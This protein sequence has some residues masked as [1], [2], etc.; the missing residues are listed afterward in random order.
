MRSRL[1]RRLKHSRFQH[2][3]E[4]ERRKDLRQLKGL[5]VLI[6]LPVLVNNDASDFDDCAPWVRYHQIVAADQPGEAAL[7]SYETVRSD[8]LKAL[9]HSG[10]AVELKHKAPEVTF[11]GVNDQPDFATLYIT[12]YPHSSVIELRSLKEY[13]YRCRNV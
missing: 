8:C 13:L 4:S 6:A 9:P 2:V 5:V 3:N 7:K 1:C 11:L 10:G 12:M